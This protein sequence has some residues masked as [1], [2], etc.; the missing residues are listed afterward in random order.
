MRAVQ[1]NRYGPA[2]VLQ[3]ADVPRPVASP[4]HIVVQVHATTVHP[5]DLLVRSGQLKL[6]TGRKF[7]KGTGLDFA[8]V[9]VD[10]APDVVDHAIGDSVWGIQSGTPGRTATAAAAEFI[11]VAAGNVA[12]KPAELDFE[13]AAALSG[14]GAVTL[15][16]LRD[17]LALRAGERLLVRG[18]AGGVGSIAI[19]YGRAV[20]AHVTALASSQML[21]AARDLGADIALDYAITKPG[22]LDR[23]DVI[24]DLAG[25]GLRGFRARLTRQGRMASLAP[26]FGQ[27]GYVLLSSLHGSRRV[28][29]FSTAPK[30]ATFEALADLVRQGAMKPVIDRVFTLDTI[31]EAHRSLE[32]GGGLGKRVVRVAG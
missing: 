7:P 15:I 18:A 20:G 32:A 25:T 5:H 2:D 12:P 23:F 11:H 6:L 31:V 10:I 14:V 30:R 22:D 26:A 16:A 28:Q 9:V 3:I 17:R 27:I 8:G 1:F 4:G 21:S 19:Q 13:A 29:F 24:L